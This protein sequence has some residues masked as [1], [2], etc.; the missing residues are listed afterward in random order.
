MSKTRKLC[1][2]SMLVAL[3][4]VLSYLSGFLRIGNITKISVSF[5]PVYLAAASF[6]PLTGGFVAAAADFI[7]YAVNPTGPFLWQMTLLE[8]GYG[9][10]AG[11]FF[12]YDFKNGRNRF[13]I[14]KLII[15]VV[16]RFV[17]DITLKTYVLISSGLIVNSFIAGMSMRIPSAIVMAVIQIVIMMLI[18]RFSKK[19]VNVI[20]GKNE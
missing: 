16:I 2:V 18:N 17:S 1:S 20:R 6:G 19:L 12:Y 10:L 3:T 4:V 11:L 9:M 5:L 8:F 15:L 7:S 13:G 14:I